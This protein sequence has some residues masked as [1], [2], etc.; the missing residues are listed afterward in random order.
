MTY[1]MIAGGWVRVETGT[2]GIAEE[3][4]RLETFQTFFRKFGIPGKVFL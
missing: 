1:D 3:E 2:G 4:K